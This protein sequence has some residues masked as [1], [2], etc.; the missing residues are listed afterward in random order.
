MK[1]EKNFDE[2]LWVFAVLYSVGGGVGGT[3][4]CEGL[5]LKG[6]CYGKWID[7]IDI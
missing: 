2:V 3:R 5:G 6:P 4:F 7:V 1:V